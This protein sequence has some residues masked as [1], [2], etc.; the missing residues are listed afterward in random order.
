MAYII[1]KTKPVD[2]HRVF[3]LIK[4]SQVP[5][6]EQKNIIHLNCPS[7]RKFSGVSE[8][9]NYLEQNTCN[10]LHEIQPYVL[11]KLSWNEAV[12]MFGF[13]DDTDSPSNSETVSE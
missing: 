13:D 4:T 11:K 8:L 3:Y 6:D 2:S 5:E 7:V 9:I 10:A 12:D 1:L